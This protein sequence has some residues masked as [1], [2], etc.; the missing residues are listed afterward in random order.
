[1]DDSS[2]VKMSSPFKVYLE[3]SNVNV[4]NI[5]CERCVTCDVSPSITHVKSQPIKNETVNGEAHKK[6]NNVWDRLY[7][8]VSPKGKRTK[9]NKQKEQKKKS[10]SKFGEY[11]DAETSEDNV[12]CPVSNN[13][14]L[15]NNLIEFPYT[16]SNKCI[17]RKVIFCIFFEVFKSTFMFLI[18]MLLILYALSLFPNME[19]SDTQVI[20]RL[21]STSTVVRRKIVI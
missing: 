16:A 10:S 19:Q 14:I 9:S 5:K 1:M 4:L 18:T 6:S 15:K 2:E 17:K 12:R 13:E 20:F 11:N 8:N 7:Y 21:R 3:A